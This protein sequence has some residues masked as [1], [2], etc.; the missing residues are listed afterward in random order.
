MLMCNGWPKR[1]MFLVGRALCLASMA[2]VPLVFA[3]TAKP[4]DKLDNATQ[5]LSRRLM[6]LRTMEADFEQRTVDGKN[7]VVRTM[8]GRIA[9]Q[10][11]NH[12]RWAPLPDED[13]QLIIA[14]NQ[15]LWVYDKDMAQVIEKPLSTLQGTNPAA[16]LSGSLEVFTRQFSVQK[17][18]PDRAG[19]GY[20]FLVPKQSGAM[21]KSLRL[22]FVGEKLVGMRI[23]DNLD[24]TSQLH[25]THII[26]NQPLHKDLFS[27]VLPKGVDVINMDAS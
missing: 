2:C 12:F 5:Q 19:G 24:Q 11:P 15:H 17:Y 26:L 4:I 23:V 14:D 8:K 27:F 3:S 25:F 16:L 6:Q 20:F 10:R 21:L 18:E 7:T 13:G 9:L 22:H 1:I